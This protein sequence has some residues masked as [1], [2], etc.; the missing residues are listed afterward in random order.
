MRRTCLLCIVALAII[1]SCWGRTEQGFYTG[2][3][4]PVADISGLPDSV[5]ISSPSIVGIAIN[6]T[7]DFYLS[8]KLFIST[9]V[10]FRSYGIETN[11]IDEGYSFHNELKFSDFFIPAL[12]NMAISETLYVQAGGI[13]A[14]RMNARNKYGQDIGDYY[15]TFYPTVH[16]G[17]KYFLTDAVYGSV[18]YGHSL[19]DL[20]TDESVLHLGIIS[21]GVGVRL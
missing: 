3:E 20:H 19:S 16:I 13:V 7:V 18:M 4:I 6:Y 8:E 5:T 17:L 21:M 15:T 11:V 14:I 1:L 2:F 10:G 12:C 9:G